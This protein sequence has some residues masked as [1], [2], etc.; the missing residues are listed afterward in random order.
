[1]SSTDFSSHPYP[2]LRPFRQEE[3]DIFFGREEHTDQ[4]L[5]RLANH[6]FLAV[7]GLSGSGKSSLVRAGLIPALNRGFVAK[8]GHLWRVAQMRPGRTP[9]ARLAGGLL[10]IGALAPERDGIA[11]GGAFVEETLRRGPMGL[12]EVLRQTPLP[13]GTNLLLVVDQFEE[14]F[15]FRTED[16][17]RGVVAPEEF[18]RERQRRIDEAEALAQLL[19]ASKDQTEFPVFVLLTMRTDFLGYCAM[20]RGLLEVINESQYIPPPLSR[21]QLIEAISAP[22]QVLKG[23][24]EETLC[25]H[26]LND[27]GSSQDQ[28]PLLQHALMRMWNLAVKEGQNPIVLTAEH[29][30]AV[31]SIRQSADGESALSRHGREVL[32]QLGSEKQRHIAEMLFRALSG[33]A[34]ERRDT[35]RFVSVQE[36]AEIGQVKPEDV[37]EV[38]DV[39]CAPGCNFITAIAGESSSGDLRP[40]TELDI[41]HESLIR[42]WDTLKHWVDREAR[43]G[44]EYCRLIGEEERYRSGQRAELTP[45]ELQN[46]LAWQH[47]YSPNAAWARRYGGD[48]QKIEA[49]LAKSRQA[50]TRQRIKNLLV[51]LSVIALIA[52]FIVVGLAVWALNQREVARTNLQIALLYKALFEWRSNKPLS[53]V[54]Y[55]PVVS[56]VNGGQLPTNQELGGVSPPKIRWHHLVKFDGPLQTVAL[57]GDQRWLATAT[58]DGEIEIIDP[59]TSG[60]FSTIQIRE[61]INGRQGAAKTEGFIPVHLAFHPEGKWLAVGVECGL[62]LWRYDEGTW[63]KMK[64]NENQLAAQS[65]GDQGV[66]ALVASAKGDIIAA[67]VRDVSNNSGVGSGESPVQLKL[68]KENGNPVCLAKAENVSE[69]VGLAFSP[70]GSRIAV[71]TEF[72]LLVFDT[73]DGKLLAFYPKPVG[74]VAFYPDGV[75]LAVGETRGKVSLW[76]LNAAPSTSD[77]AKEQ[78]PL[79]LSKNFVPESLPFSLRP[80]KNQEAEK[81]AD[82]QPAEAHQTKAPGG[83]DVMTQLAFSPDGACLAWTAGDSYLNFG[84][85]NPRSQPDPA[86]SAF[87]FLKAHPDPVKGFALASSGRFAVTVSSEGIARFWEITSEEELRSAGESLI[88]PGD[89]CVCAGKVVTVIGGDQGQLRVWRDG[90]GVALPIDDD[91]WNS[92]SALRAY[93]PNGNRIVLGFTPELR[94]FDL[95]DLQKSFPKINIQQGYSYVDVDKDG[96]ILAV[97]HEGILELWDAEGKEREP[98]TTIEKIAVE[99]LTFANNHQWVAVGDRTTGKGKIWDYA[100]PRNPKDIY[101]LPSHEPGMIHSTFSADD[102]HLGWVSAKGTVYVWEIQGSQAPFDL[103]IDRNRGT[104]KALRFSPFGKHLAL[105]TTTGEV[106]LWDFETGATTFKQN[107][108]NSAGGLAFMADADGTLLVGCADRTVQK[109]KIE[110]DLLRESGVIQGKDWRPSNAAD[111]AKLSG[112]RLDELSLEPTFISASE[113]FGKAPSS[114]KDELDLTGFWRTASCLQDS[115]NKSDFAEDEQSISYSIALD[116]WLEAHKKAPRSILKTGKLLQAK[117]KSKIASQHTE[118]GLDALHRGDD[119][120]AQKE[121]EIANSISENPEASAFLDFLYF[122]KGDEDPAKLNKHRLLP[123]GMLKRLQGDATGRKAEEVRYKFL[124]WLDPSEP[125]NFVYLGLTHLCLGQPDKSVTDLQ[126]ALEL[127]KM[128]FQAPVAEARLFLAR[129]YRAKGDAKSAEDQLQRCSQ[130]EPPEGKAPSR[131]LRSRALAKALLGD[132]SGAE[133]DCR[134]ALDAENVS[135]ERR[136]DYEYFACVYALQAEREPAGSEAM[137]NDLKSAADQLK[138]AK[139]DL[140]T[141]LQDFDDL[142]FSETLS[143]SPEFQ[144]SSQLSPSESTGTKGSSN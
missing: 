86:L 40:E 3:T 2:G 42:H 64:P 29:Y 94:L 44:I 127:F 103:P 21:D 18:Q 41:S 75:H 96:K 56:K 31:G 11:G 113:D 87:L 47:D 33:G 118:H 10:E 62:S 16:E 124:S 28:L 34:A 120:Q 36:V 76:S 117:V 19:L 54:S 53:M 39:F 114:L 59:M 32:D 17:A 141:F 102:T 89:L 100:D 7:T 72:G 69:S 119:A 116:S 46:A 105:E 134:L 126:H 143:H 108:T 38:A 71:A 99:G 8:A 139:I 101:E 121:F 66:S 122:Q 104:I 43:A 50:A 24:V 58:K 22:A 79:P 52:L 51:P 25:H 45:L 128:R 26:L 61:L 70:D 14:I 78:P 135:S 137:A 112:L 109:Y 15:R 68:Y 1:M 81:P 90:N 138:Q 129:A 95:E 35:R 91:R 13:A 67:V 111:A 12:V 74:S 60:P 84:F 82:P 97:P 133:D 142:K 57:S 93:T 98:L 115:M 37:M 107:R 30:T 123:E 88:P 125:E 6:R 140:Q 4:L 80:I 27:A 106:G 110:G 5:E 83:S 73:K 55:L 92:F 77:G 20:F 48:Y 63:T 49:F 132:A 144:R 131:L 65:I 130:I 23:R 85:L 9:F 136:L